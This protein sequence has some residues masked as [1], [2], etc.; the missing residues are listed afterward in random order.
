M[1]IV[2]TNKRSNTTLMLMTMIKSFMLMF[3]SLRGYAHDNPLA[4]NL[5]Y[6]DDNYRIDNTFVTL[7]RAN[8]KVTGQQHRQPEIQNTLHA[9]F[10]LVAY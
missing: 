4:Y 2:T 8:D 9:D 1:R 6:L 3:E 5:L 7:H 10:G